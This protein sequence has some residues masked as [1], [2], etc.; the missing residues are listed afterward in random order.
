MCEEK[1]GFLNPALC[2]TGMQ[3]D[4]EAGE[5]SASHK[6]LLNINHKS[7]IWKVLTLNLSP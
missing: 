5:A 7:D 4:S 1:K 2:M 3:G 6:K